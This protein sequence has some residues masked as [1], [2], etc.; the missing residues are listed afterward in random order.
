LVETTLFVL[1]CKLCAHRRAYSPVIAVSNLSMDQVNVLG[2]MV[3]AVDLARAAGQIE[4]AIA[5]KRKGYVCVTG[6]HGVMEAQK[7]PEFKAILNQSLLT[8]PDGMPTVWVGKLQGVKNIDRVYGPDLMSEL[9]SRSM[10]NGYTHFLYGGAPGVVDQL[11]DALRAWYPNL[12][13][14]GTHTPPFRSLSEIELRELKEKV[15]AL[16]PDILWVGLSTPKQERFMA[17]HGADL[18]ATVTI[19]VGAAF[20][21]HSGNLRDA[22]AWVKKAG[23]QWCHRLIQE[24]RRLWRRYLLNNPRFLWRIALQ[25]LRAKECKLG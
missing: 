21:I 1:V 23:L 9:C 22:P 11:R 8:V 25:M 16:N 19:G 14:V 12:R 6:V 13:I 10:Q 5:E 15:G 4:R 3:H 20:D 2:V 7:D 17:G 18:A 24:P